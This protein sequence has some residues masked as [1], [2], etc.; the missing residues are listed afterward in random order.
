MIF[1]SIYQKGYEAGINAQKC[2]DHEDQNRRLEY[3]LKYGKEIGYAK[4]REDGMHE[5]YRIG[6]DCGCDDMATKYG[7]VEIDGIETE[8]E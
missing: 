2:A 6:Y 3:M 8:G 1:D 7:I 4:G 5:G